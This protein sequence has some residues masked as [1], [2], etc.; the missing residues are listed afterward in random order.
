MHFK[1]AYKIL[2]DGQKDH[3]IGYLFGFM[4][5]L[6]GIPS[7]LALSIVFF[8]ENKSFDYA[9]EHAIDVS[10]NKIDSAFDGKL[11]ITS[12]FA[13]TSRILEDNVF[14]I[15]TNA[16]NLTRI[17]SMYQCYNKRGFSKRWSKLEEA[18][19]NR[20][21]RFPFKSQYIY[22][23]DITIGAFKIKKEDAAIFFRDDIYVKNKYPISYG[24]LK[25]GFHV[26][27]NMYYTM[28]N[29][30]NP[31]IGDLIVE[32]F[33][34]PQ[35]MT[36]II[37]K[38]QGEYLVPLKIKNTTVAIAAQGAFSKQDLLAIKME[39]NEIVMY[40]SIFFCLLVNFFGFLLI[41]PLIKKHFKKSPN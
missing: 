26:Y 21:P 2:N 7:T 11:V 40:G 34:I 23:D 16:L 35:G 18:C 9:L 1:E 28:V 17:V 22:A 38:Q 41:L 29:P 31:E 8:Q 4:L 24:N 15:K 30:Q 36:T 12:G 33:Y 19:M 20:N 13:Q 5:L 14:P 25:E 39:T 6:I 3:S 10:S 27:E 37:G 32:F